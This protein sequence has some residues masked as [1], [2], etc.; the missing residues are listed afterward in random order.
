MDAPTDRDPVSAQGV[1]GQHSMVATGHPA[2]ARA[3]H[4]MLQ[5][6]GSAVDAAI[7]ADAILGVVEPMATGIGGDVLAM[8]VEPD[9]TAITY[10]GTGRAP[11]AWR[12][13]LLAALP[14]QK[15]PERHALT[16]TT[17]GA[18]RGWF[19]LHARYGRLPF[20]QLLQP[21]IA[22]A[23]AGFAVAPIAAREWAL[24]APVLHGD[25]VSARLYRAEQP[26][27]AGERF[28]NPELATVL[29]D[30]ACGGADAFYRGRPAQAA[31]QASERH[32]GILTAQDFAEHTGF[33]A[34]PLR[35]EFR[36][37]TVLA[38]PPNT[39]G[40]AVLEALRELEPQTLLRDEPR[41]VLC[42]V[43]AMRRAMRRAREEV[44]DPA[45]TVCTAIIDQD[46]LGISLMS[47]VFK[48]FGSGISADGCGFV[49]QNRGFGF[50]RP[51]TR[52][53]P[54]AAKRPYHT[55]VPGGTLRDG[56][57][58]ACFG[59]VGGAMQPQGQVQILERL[60]AFGQGLQEALDA[61]RWRLES[62]TALAIEAGTPPEVT[63]LLRAS[64]FV[65]PV[66]EGELGG[67][68][69]FG[70]AQFAMRLADGSLLGASDK[71]KDGMALGG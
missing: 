13:E 61:P 63:A 50:G 22:M 69:D 54:G 29:E 14:Q 19:D 15:I 1:H 67:R 37:L 35:A 59:V 18:V 5:S 30:I 49:L 42:T 23:R 68:S 58:H 64:G 38:C 53:A 11:R 55:V 33:F 4:A 17:P 60:A 65:D 52:N 27:Q 20:A 10:N 16:L 28:S 62:D 43:Q 2:A 56:R 66:G 71:R 39:H 9:G 26:P 40:M 48:R 45:G 12:D 41:T 47:S 25:A 21:A 6:G 32:G 24:F 44:A 8:L 7:A 57:L 34:P 3:A 46:G 70:G 36:G 51:G 31:Q